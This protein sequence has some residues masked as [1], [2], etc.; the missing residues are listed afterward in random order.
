METEEYVYF[1][2]LVIAKFESQYIFLLNYWHIPK[3][4]Q[5]IS[6]EWHTL[7]KV[8][9]YVVLCWYG[10]FLRWYEHYDNS[11]HCICCGN[12]LIHLETSVYVALFYVNL[13][14]KLRHFFEIH[15][16]KFYQQFKVFKNFHNFQEERNEERNSMS[17]RSTVRSWFIYFLHTAKSKRFSSE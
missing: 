7:Y 5:E 8:K 13:L 1:Y 11:S 12:E 2:H 10:T 17:Q 16:L 4:A 3:V 9:M 6:V 15:V 14:S